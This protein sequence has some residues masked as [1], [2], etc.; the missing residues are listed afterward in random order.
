MFFF[1]YLGPIKD[2]KRTR[3]RLDRSVL[4]AAGQL[5][6]SF[7]HSMNARKCAHAQKSLTPLRH[8]RMNQANPEEEEQREGKRQERQSPEGWWK[9]RQSNKRK[10]YL[11]S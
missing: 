9:E 5:P 11:R 8:S 3:V 2:T 4:H 6:M 7:A 10:T 1:N